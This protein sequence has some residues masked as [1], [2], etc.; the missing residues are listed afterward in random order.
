MSRNDDW[1]SGYV[2]DIEYTTNFCGD[3]TPARLAFAL[4]AQDHAAPDLDSAF[5]YCEL[6]CGQGVTTSLM[7][8]VHPNASFWANDFNPTHIGN[9]RKLAAAANLDNVRFAEASFAEFCEADL[10]Q[11]DFISLHG[12]WTWVSEENRRA[13]LR[14]IRARLKIGGVVY[15]SYNAQPG[16]AALQPLQR[17]LADHAANGGEP[18]EARI[19]R[20]VAFAERLRGTGARY[21]AANPAAGERLDKIKESSPNY[22]AHEYLAADFVPAYHAD[23]V[24]DFAEAKLTYACSANIR[25]QVDAF[26]FDPQQQA[27]L[28]GIAAPVLRETIRDF[29]LAKRFRQDIFTRGVAR[30]GARESRARWLEARFA[31]TRKRAE[32]PLVVQTPFGEATLHPE[33]YVPLL[34]ALAGGPATVRELLAVP[35]L[36]ALGPE[37]AGQALTVLAGTEMVE[38]CL[39]ARGDAARAARTRAFN[40]AC[41]ERVQPSGALAWMASPVTGSGIAVAGVLQLFLLARQSG[42]QDDAE[43][44]WERLSAQGVRLKKDGKE[45]ESPEENLAEL[46][47]AA[48]RAADSMPVFRQLG[49]I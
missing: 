21:F 35:A 19:R 43:Y 24:R 18:T 11:F 1:T 33:V 13:I 2:S 22:L 4:L 5:N 28:A 8:A 25:H 27:L 38:P 7:A 34:D 14:F 40:L 10:P 42:R 17:L 9:A 20:A 6:G 41:L 12:I 26:Q 48:A 39:G 49:L 47:L 36:G 29:I 15:V 44:A 16:W 31:L 30:L 23:V 3:I 32:A 37:R 46:R 45:I